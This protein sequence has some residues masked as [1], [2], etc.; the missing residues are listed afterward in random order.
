MPRLDFAWAAL[1][2]L[3]TIYQRSIDD[4]GLEQA[5]TYMGLIGEALALLLD[6]PLVGTLLA[7][8]SNGTRRRS[9][10]SHVIYYRLLGNRLRVLRVLHQRMDA[11]RHL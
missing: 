3:D 8:R 11:D 4:H 7:S 5:D 10:G 1:A 9:V 6:Y 2:D